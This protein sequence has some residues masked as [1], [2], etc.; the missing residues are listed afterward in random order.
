MQTKL[1]GTLM[2]TQSIVMHQRTDY[3]LIF[4]DL[5][6]LFDA[7]ISF[8]LFINA[9]L[10]LTRLNHFMPESWKGDYQL[11]AQKVLENNAKDLHLQTLQSDIIYLNKTGMHQNDG[12][13]LDL[14]F[15]LTD[16]LL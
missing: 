9:M 16:F 5:K 14:L 10:H 3:A 15:G 1:F 2:L 11:I 8:C 6:S 7:L 12:G 13:F 4:S